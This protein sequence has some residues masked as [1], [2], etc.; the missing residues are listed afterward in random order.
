MIQPAP[1]ASTTFSTSFNVPRELQRA[2][3]L[4]RASRASTFSNRELATGYQ[5]RGEERGQDCRIVSGQLVTRR[6]EGGERTGQSSVFCRLSAVRCQ[7]SAVRCRLS[8]QFC[9]DSSARTA[10]Q[11]FSASLLSSLLAV[12]AKLELSNCLLSSWEPE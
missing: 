4:Q 10:L 5:E 6:E 8:G 1:K 7:L 12:L 11:V 9:K 2:R 3:T